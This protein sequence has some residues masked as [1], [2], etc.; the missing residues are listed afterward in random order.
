MQ[1]PV[2]SCQASSALPSW[3][4]QAEGKSSAWQGVWNRVQPSLQEEG[5]G[6]K[7]AN[8]CVLCGGNLQ[9]ERHTHTHTHC[10]L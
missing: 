6:G 3:R 2:V 4:G 1:I 8:S 7:E 9:I 10:R 5:A